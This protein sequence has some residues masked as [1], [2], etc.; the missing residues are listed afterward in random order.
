MPVFIC[1]WEC[2]ADEGAADVMSFT[3]L[4]NANANVRPFFEH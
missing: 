3:T 2:D 4:A 1:S